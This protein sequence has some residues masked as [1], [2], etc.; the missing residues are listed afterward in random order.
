MD[1][2]QRFNI[3]TA[4]AAQAA[5]LTYSFGGTIVL[6][7]SQEDLFQLCSRFPLNSQCEGYDV[8]I[9][10]DN[11]RGEEAKCLLSGAEDAAACRLLLGEELLSVY[12]EFGDGLR[13][14]GGAHDTTEVIIPLSTIESFEYS[15]DSKVD[16]GAIIAFG[17]AGLFMKDKT[18]TFD[19]RYTPESVEVDEI[20]DIDEGGETDLAETDVEETTLEEDTEE[21]VISEQASEQL[22]FVMKRG[23]GRDMRQQLEDATGLRAEI[24]SID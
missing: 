4:I 24:T 2:R 19:I 15:E 11:R 6:A 23:R 13:V 18:A 5:V 12:V 9:P 7:N 20:V 14:L 16:A 21:T 8:P 22:L 17:L 3:L 10:L 1:N